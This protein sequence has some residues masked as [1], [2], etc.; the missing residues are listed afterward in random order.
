MGLADD[1]KKEIRS[2]FKDQWTFRD[3]TVV[4]AT[5]D[6]KLGNDGV[7]LQ[8]VVL[9]ADMAESTSLVQDK[10]DWFAAEIYKAYLKCCCKIISDAGGSIT[11]FDG[12]RVMAVFIGDYKNTMAVK[13]AMKI[14]YG[15][16]HI[17]NPLLK[18]CY[19]DTQYEVKY[20]I[21][22]DSSD[23]LVARTGI[24]GS[25]D[26][27]WV[28]KAANY[29]AKMCD[30]KDD[31]FSTWISK[32]VFSSMTDEVKYDSN[33]KMMWEA[34]TWTKYNKTVYGSNYWWRF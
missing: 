5:D 32:D 31:G 15:V 10:K 12:D 17:L 34:R 18:E 6:V 26:L 11:A 21:G 3:G 7:R 8:G 16:T 28:G 27:V 4:P 19:P 29:A 23:L 25:N 14:K 9:Y 33:K 20:G 2:T 30:L 22:V 24:R 1:L 13:T